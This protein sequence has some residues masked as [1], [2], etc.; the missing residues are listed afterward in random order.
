MQRPGGPR[1]GARKP[2][3]LRRNFA[4]DIN[5]KRRLA[6]RFGSMA[7]KRAM[8]A[9]VLVFGLVGGAF[10]ETLPEPGADYWTKAK[11]TG[12]MTIEY[13]HSKGKVRME[14]RAPGMNET[15][16]G[17]FD[18]KSRKGIMVMSMP[19][20]PPMA[21]ESGLDGEGQVGVAGGKGERIG[22]DRVAGEACDL[23]KPEMNN[24][25]EKRMDG[26]ACITRDGIMLRMVGNLEGKRQ[27]IFEVTELSRA[28]QD[29]KL[30]TPPAG[31][32]PMQ[33][34]KGMMPPRK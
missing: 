14:M 24:A 32:K 25:E 23:W 27:T 6:E 31:L 33:I 29:M 28:A 2:A 3:R 21:I 22:S 17:Y 26:V 19:G 18:V 7:M 5:H 16:V 34:P 9:G 12:G 30:L 15:M 11:M 13:R 8:A 10:A 4:H 20:M 1:A